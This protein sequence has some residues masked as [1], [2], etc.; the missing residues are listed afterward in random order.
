M[1]RSIERACKI[2]KIGNSK[3]II[4][5]KDTLEYLKL[6]VGDWVKIQI[7]KVENNEED[8]KK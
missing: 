1:V 4:I 5:D 6:K 3:G 7:E 2:L 8:N